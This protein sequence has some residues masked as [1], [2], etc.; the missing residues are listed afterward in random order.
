M[1][2]LI[3]LKKTTALLLA[4]LLVSEAQAEEKNEPWNMG[5]F[6]QIEFFDKNPELSYKYDMCISIGTNLV[7]IMTEALG[8]EGFKNQVKP[9]ER[10]EFMQMM[11][12]IKDYRS[13]DIQYVVIKKTL[14]VAMRNP[15][16]PKLAQREIWDYC[17]K[18]DTVY[19]NDLQ[20]NVPA[21]LKID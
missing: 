12:G 14:E 10:L 8:S 9:E 6:E 13:S 18:I 5:V 19:F 15:G 1:N 4:L 17:M 7:S 3:S 20:D 16:K 11:S 21:N 2:Q